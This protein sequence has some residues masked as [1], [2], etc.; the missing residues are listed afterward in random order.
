MPNRLQKRIDLLALAFMAGRIDEV[1]QNY[2]SDLTVYGA[3]GVLRFSTADEVKA[4]LVRHREKAM[5]EGMEALHGV[6]VVQS[7]NPSSRFQFHVRWRYDMGPLNPVR[8]ADIA[9]FCRGNGSAAKVEMIE[10]RKLAF[11]AAMSWYPSNLIGGRMP[12]LVA[13][14]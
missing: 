7:L 10:F 14:R 1:V 2:T 9:Y 8:Y 6:V 5:E 3:D 12:T 11:P 13:I 4:A